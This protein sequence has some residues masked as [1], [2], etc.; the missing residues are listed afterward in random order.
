MHAGH[1]DAAMD[2]VIS[3]ADNP[4]VA[5]TRSLRLVTITHFFPAHG[6]GLELVAGKLV[7][8]LAARG[9]S[10]Q[11][12]SSATDDPPHSASA[13]VTCVPVATTNLVERLTQLPYP[14]WSP[15]ALSRMWRAIG[16]ADVVHVHE[17]LYACSIVAI[18]LARLRRRPVVIT[19]HMGALG[20]GSRAL[21]VCYEVAAK[22]LGLF[23]FA[24]A[25]R[26]VFIS[27]NVRRFFSQDRSDR[28][29]LIFN[30]IDTERFGA[31]SNDERQAA[32]EQLGF[33]LDRRVILFVGRFVR[34]KG[35]S[36]I[37]E[38]ARRFPEV[39]WVLVGSGPEDPAKWTR[40]NVRLPGRVNHDGLPQFYHA[41]DLL[42]LPSTGEGFPLVVQEALC[43]GLG[44]LSTDEVGTA[45]PA[46]A[47]LIRV[48][49]TPR[50]GSDYDGWENALRQ[51][52][53]DNAYLE[54]RKARSEQ[55]RR[56]WSWKNCSS[57]Y[58]QLFE[59]LVRREA[60]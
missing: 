14:L 41:A 34:K 53:A 43:C 25:T 3:R 57:Q 32:R 42:L 4:A 6:G 36:I 30:G 8:A 47:P 12:F 10:T 33:P 40:E 13:R 1:D 58:L 59:S 56:L 31:A 38:L 17:H 52:L 39:L 27:A 54:A 18:V 26:T 20:L 24:L 44:V 55:A 28:S 9:V 21:T 51:V 2:S 37:N 50:T 16:S 23:A 5:E 19:Q 48:W 35:L 15:G 45:C 46:A 11:W 7:D 29:L 49:R 22:A 60:R